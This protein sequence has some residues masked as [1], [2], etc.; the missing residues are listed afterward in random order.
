MDSVDK[1]IGIELCTYS[2]ESGRV[3]VGSFDTFH[4]F[5]YLACGAPEDLKNKLQLEN[6]SFSVSLK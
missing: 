2:L 5:Y 4:I 6:I 1:S 3:C